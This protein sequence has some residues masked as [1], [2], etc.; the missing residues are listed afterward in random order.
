MQRLLLVGIFTILTLASLAANAVAQAPCSGD[1]MSSD[2][3][4]CHNEWVTRCVSGNK[5]NRAQCE[6]QIRLKYSQQHALQGAVVPTNFSC[7]A[8][9]LIKGNFTTYDG[10]RCIF[11]VPGGQFYE[12]TKPEM[13]YRSPQDAIADGC[14]QSLR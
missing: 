14:R 8:T 12:A 4:A 9:H 13:C 6:N 5:V 10:E 3:I 2:W 7:P 1:N 11:H